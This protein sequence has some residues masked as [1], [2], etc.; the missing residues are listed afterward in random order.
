[1]RTVLA[2]TALALMAASP[3]LAQQETEAEQPK[4]VREVY[5]AVE[6][7]DEDVFREVEINGTFKKPSGRVIRG[8][9]DEKFDSII[10][11]RAHFKRDL[12]KSIRVNVKVAETVAK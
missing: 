3:A 8:R 6:T 5:N 11:E 12:A 7:H 10:D 9:G 2:A 4:R 1:M